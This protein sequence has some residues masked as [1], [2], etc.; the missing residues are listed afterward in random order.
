MMIHKLHQ[1]NLPGGETFHYSC[2]DFDVVCSSTKG[3]FMPLCCYE[4]LQNLALFTT[5]L[6]H[7]YG[8]D[9]ELDAGSALGSVKLD[10]TLMWDIDHDF[11]V[12]SAHIDKL[13]SLQSLFNKA[14]YKLNNGNTYYNSGCRKKMQCGYVAVNSLSWKM[15]LWGQKLLSSD[16]YKNIKRIPYERDTLGLTS[17]KGN[18]TLSR[19]GNAW[20]AIMSQSWCIF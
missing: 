11:N 6:Y 12:R 17:V 7:Q 10:G 19:L 18:K 20:L 9:Y 16:I 1:I 8:I 4:E 2:D 5:N 15:D 13:M 14:G 3:I